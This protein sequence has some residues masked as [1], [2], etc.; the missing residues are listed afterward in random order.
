[1]RGGDVQDSLDSTCHNVACFG[2]WALIEG[3]QLLRL[4]ADTAP[5][6]HYS[7]TAVVLIVLPDLASRC[8]RCLGPSLVGGIPVYD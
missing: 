8:C 6:C 2:R 7:V 3:R 5:R 4:P 1:M